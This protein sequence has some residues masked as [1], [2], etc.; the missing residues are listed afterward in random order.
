MIATPLRLAVPAA[1]SFEARGSGLG[2]L[3]EFVRGADRSGYVA[4]NTADLASAV[5]VE[6]HLVRRAN[7]AG[8]MVAAADTSTVDSCFRELALRLGGRRL[9]SDPGDAARALTQQAGRSLL[10]IVGHIARGSW[11]DEV[12]REVVRTP[13][14][15][16]I[17][18][19]TESPKS[20]ASFGADDAIAI[21]ASSPQEA[22]VW[23]GGVLEEAP[24]VMGKRTLAQLDRWWKAAVRLE[25]SDGA[26][27][28]G[29]AA[30][31]LLSRLLLARRSWPEAHVEDLGSREALR[32]L[33]D[34]GVVS[35]E[36][37]W[38]VVSPAVELPE[39]ED[40]NQAIGVAQWLSARFDRDPWAQARASELFTR[41]GEID[42]GETSLGN[43]L[44]EVDSILARRQ[45][46]TGWC[47][48][49]GDAQEEQRRG[50]ELRGAEL[51]LELDDVDVAMRLAQAA[52]SGS[53]SPTRRTSFV[54]G[55]AQLAR[56]D[57][58]AAK[59]SFERALESA[60][61]PDRAEILAYLA[62]QAYLAGHLED[63]RRV[64]SDAL[65]AQ[66]GPAENLHARNTLGKLL[67]ARSEWEA[68]EAHFAADEYDAALAGLEIAELRARV[69]R[70][71]ALLSRRRTEEARG[72]L[73]SVLSDAEKRRD[74]RATAFA[75]SNLAVLAIERQDY[76]EAIT[77]CERAIDARR[78]LGDKIGLARVIA[79][80]AELR[81]R[82]GLFDEAEQVLGFG[83]GTL[84]SSIP[85]AYRAV[86]ALI[87]GSIQYA[88]GDTV[89][90]AKE[91]TLAFSGIDRWTDGARMG[92]CHRLAARIALE[93]GDTRGAEASLH[94][95]RKLADSDQAHAETTLLE[96]HLARAMGRRATELAAKALAASADARDRDLMREANLL[97]CDLARVEER[98]DLAAA[99]LRSAEQ[100]R[101]QSATGLPAGLRARYL[102]RR[103]IAALTEAS[104]LV[105]AGLETRPA[106]AVAH[107]V[108]PLAEVPG[109]S[110]RFAGRHPSVLRLLAS[111]RKVAR[112]NAPVLILGESG[113]GKE[114]IAETIHAWSDRAAGPLIKVNCAALVETLLL[115]ELFGHEKGAFTGAVAR[116]RGRFELADGGTL[117]LDEIGDI[118][119]RT[120]VALLRVL[121]D[122]TF[123]RVGGTNPI[124]TDVRI[125]CAT[126]RDLQAMVAAGT[127][128]EDL[129]YRLRGVTLDVPPLRR[130]IEDV[131]VLAA[132]M[133]PQIARE[134]REPVRKLSTEALALLH[135]H[136]WPGNVRELENVL[137]AASLFAEGEEITADVIEEQL[138]MHSSQSSPPAAAAASCPPVTVRSAGAECAQSDDNTSQVAWDQIRSQRTSL[139]DLKRQIERDCIERALAETEGNITR[140]ATLLGMKRPRLSQLVK[141]YGLLEQTSEEC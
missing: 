40:A 127:F 11:D 26:P 115:S 46:W 52:A 70:A 67:L 48:A 29:E 90:A 110:A 103:D 113:T 54:L 12:L 55:R 42:R 61:S 47:E 4:V 82:L 50:G 105:R 53:A 75:L 107:I 32:E 5:A 80:L 125:V 109:A 73:D 45:L 108:A 104:R 129:Y 95:A 126:N 102:A 10:L 69:N 100:L 93:D 7:A 96:A 43:A 65:E 77:L 134:R 117:F 122:Q 89:E 111:V 137:R 72:M 8:R 128:R 133:L 38:L 23:W 3:D 94:E 85:E 21:D 116:R 34:A 87:S 78:R 114:L 135:R 36:H 27:K 92:E 132:F 79:N 9:P 68:A 136:V 119:P 86:F 98:F 101:D 1:P 106:P 84:G 121:Q 16:L 66:P 25:V 141:Q 37:G 91:L 33:L 28:L 58:V 139:G 24:R 59:V 39:S 51:A 41:A 97:L 18:H 13:G 57:L 131:G 44:R 31:L 19:V 112:S 30:T 64:A 2:T 124:R 120:Q 74:L 76:V 123:D 20:A 62:E 99:Y 60:G 130:R 49:I 63:A 22:E 56:G 118:S 35:N 140:A 14:N 6:R 15:A 83:R 138:C 17:V 88:R 71:V 81:L